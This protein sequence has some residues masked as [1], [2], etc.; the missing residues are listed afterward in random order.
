MGDRVIEQQIA[1][2]RARA[3]EYDEWFLRQGRYDRGP[4]HRAEW[5]SEVAQV[6]AALAAE[7]PGGSTL[8]LACGTGWWTTRLAERSSRVVAVDASP[9]AIALNRARVQS[10]RVR[11]VVADVFSWRSEETFDL[12][13]FSFWLSHVPDARCDEFWTFVQTRLK[14]GGRA[15]FIDSLLEHTSTARDQG[16]LDR[17]GVARRK[18]N[19][20]REFEIVK[21]FYEPR[22]LE[23][24]LRERGWQGWVRSS[25]RYFLFGSMMRSDTG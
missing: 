16:P 20:G 19:N 3:A 14:P 1:Y 5:F 12:V 13:F 10:E 9:E 11:Y 8:E 25:G 21:I 24:R 15:F 23:R 22:G 2:Y 7:V 18:L 17:S 4:E 6:E